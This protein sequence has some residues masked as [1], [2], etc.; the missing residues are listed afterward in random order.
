MP[1]LGVEGVG[2]TAGVMP[3]PSP[4]QWGRVP[5]QAYFR[6]GGES[7]FPAHG[8][9]GLWPGRA[10]PPGDL[11]PFGPFC[12]QA[13]HCQFCSLPDKAAQGG[14][15]VNSVSSSV[16][17]R[18]FQFSPVGLNS[19]GKSQRSLA[20]RC[21]P[22]IQD[23]GGARIS[24]TACP[25]EWHR[26]RRASRGNAA[27]GADYRGLQGQFFQQARGRH[28]G[29]LPTPAG[30]VPEFRWGRSPRGSTM[31]RQRRLGTSTGVKRAMLPG[32]LW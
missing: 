21:S 22:G 23:K 9:Y 15:N 29:I 8:V 27:A 19:K 31:L 2:G 24:G 26:R 11:V 20:R 6:P 5:F 4:R 18:G 14:G 16:P 28:P 30:P 25:G 13:D 32:W 17:A 3:M 12:A 1:C 7:V 10:N